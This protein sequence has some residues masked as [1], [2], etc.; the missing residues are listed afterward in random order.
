MAITLRNDAKQEIINILREEGYATY[1]TLVDYFRI[2]LTD[3]PEVIG[4][5]VPQKAMIVINGGLSISQVSLIIRHE[6]LHEFLTHHE[7]QQAFDKAHP[8]LLPELAGDISNIAADYEISNRGYTD[9]DKASARAIILGDKVLRGLVTEDEYPDWENATFEEM[10]K[11]LLEKNKEDRQALQKL[12]NQIASLSKKDLDELMDDI[13]DAGGGSGMPK[14]GI[15]SDEMNGKPQSGGS[16]KPDDE[17]P[18][19]KDGQPSVSGSGKLDKDTQAKLD[20]LAQATGRAQQELDDLEDKTKNDD[21]VFD[22]NEDVKA[23]AEL[24]KRVG[25]IKRIF[26]DLKIRDAILDNSDQVKRAEKAAKAARDVQRVQASP[27]NKFKLSLSRFIA[28]QISD[29]ESETYARINPSYED[30]EFLLPGRMNKEEK[31]IPTINVYWDVSGSFNDPQKTEGARRAIATLNQY[32]NAGDIEIKT[33]YFAD[34]VSDKKS[35]AGGGTRGTPILEHVKSTKPTNVIVITDD[36]ITDC[37]EVVKVPGAVW[38]LFYGSG[39]EN[40][41]SHLLGKRQTRSYLISF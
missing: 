3:D 15:P 21:S 1:A 29:E 33:F 38:Y 14:D 7:R 31:N 6:I 28:D 35:S 36:D 12:L 30:S 32:V 17:K 16:G 20:K 4:Y 34:R 9:K 25:E 13:Q 27:L 24:A 2:Y 8:D 37:N 40:I 11:D 18:E 26:N 5:M 22:S 19:D 41:A 10:Y 39:S 23:K